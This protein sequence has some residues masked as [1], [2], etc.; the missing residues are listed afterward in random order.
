MEKYYNF[1]ETYVINDLIEDSVMMKNKGA[2][3]FVHRRKVEEFIKTQ[4]NQENAQK[5]PGIRLSS[6]IGIFLE[7][8]VNELEKKQ[9]NE[10]KFKSKED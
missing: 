3:Q 2:A 10:L 6:E 5:F 1:L 4:K 9:I 7:L 8:I